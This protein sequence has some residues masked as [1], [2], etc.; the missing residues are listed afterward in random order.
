VPAALSWLCGAELDG[1]LAAAANA[2]AASVASK[3]KVKV[4]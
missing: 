4:S 3:R 2:T 1:A